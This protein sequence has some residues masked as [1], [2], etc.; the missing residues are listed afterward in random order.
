MGWVRG[1]ERSIDPI[2][3]HLRDLGPASQ[4]RW[5][6]QLPPGR[7]DLGGG[8]G[9]DVETLWKLLGAKMKP[10]GTGSPS[11]GLG[12]GPT[13]GRGSCR[14][15]A[16]CPDCAHELPGEL[17]VM[18]LLREKSGVGPETQHFSGIAVAAGPSAATGPSALHCGIRAW[19][20]VARPVDSFLGRRSWN[21]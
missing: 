4:P 17:V 1:P 3:C 13:W 19:G 15:R 11:L 12:L 9:E 21:A 10:A 8:R 5:V 18:Q 14:T 20:D 16:P 6:L 7:A 2:T